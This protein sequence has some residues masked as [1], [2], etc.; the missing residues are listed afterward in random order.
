MQHIITK[1][2]SGG[3]ITTRFTQV[4][5]LHLWRL[6]YKAPP[7]EDENHLAFMSVYV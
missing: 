6:V 2:N 4:G 1:V 3:K 7:P 5:E